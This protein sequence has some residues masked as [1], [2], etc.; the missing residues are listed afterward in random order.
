MI[1]KTLIAVAAS[2]AVATPAFA[3]EQ[4]GYAAYLNATAQQQQVHNILASRGFVVTSQLSRDATGHWVG[5]ALKDGKS[6][7]VA[8]KLPPRGPAAGLTN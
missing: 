1:R 2:I 6:I 8:V 7:N 4:T 3:A 5:T